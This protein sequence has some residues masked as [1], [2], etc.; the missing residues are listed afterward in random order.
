MWAMLQHHFVLSFTGISFSRDRD[1]YRPDDMILVSPYMENGTLTQWRKNANP[2]VTETWERVW[3]LFFYSLLTLTPDEDTG[4]GPRHG[5][6]SL[7]RDCSR[8]FAGGIP[9]DRMIF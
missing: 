7:G 5:I 2:S 1:Y 3:L 8:R 9:T 6:H 4:S